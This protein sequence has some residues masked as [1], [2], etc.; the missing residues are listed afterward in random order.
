MAWNNVCHNSVG[1]WWF[2]ARLGAV[3]SPN[4]YKKYQELHSYISLIIFET[5]ILHMVAKCFFFQTYFLPMGSVWVKYYMVSKY[6]TRIYK[7]MTTL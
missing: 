3:Y 7:K 2:S 4:N 1:M 6:S 5:Y